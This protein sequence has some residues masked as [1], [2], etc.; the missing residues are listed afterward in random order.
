MYLCTWYFLPLWRVGS[1]QYCLCTWRRVDRAGWW[2]RQPQP[3]GTEGRPCTGSAWRRSWHTPRGTGAP[4]PY[5]YN[6]QNKFFHK[7]ILLYLNCWR[8]THLSG[9][10]KP[11][12]NEFRAEIFLLSSSFIVYSFFINFI[13]AF[14][15]S[16]PD[17]STDNPI[18][19]THINNLSKFYMNLISNIQ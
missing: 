13:T 1:L 6:M 17:N 8:K 15:K 3:W 4:P 18:N 11:L 16:L 5:C 14:N 7:Y 10:W 9:Y 12:V 19:G 2:V